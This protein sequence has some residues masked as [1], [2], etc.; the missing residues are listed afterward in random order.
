VAYKLP[1]SGVQ[2]AQP[3]LE[4]APAADE[5]AAKK[6]KDKQKYKVKL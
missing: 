1:V 2:E 4:K 3:Q 5:P 6:E